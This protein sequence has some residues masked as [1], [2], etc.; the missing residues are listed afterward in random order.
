[1]SLKT[2]QKHDFWQIQTSKPHSNTPYTDLRVRLPF[3]L[4]YFLTSLYRL[5]REI[6]YFIFNCGCVKFAFSLTDEVEKK[7]KKSMFQNVEEFMFIVADV[8]TSLSIL[9]SIR[10]YIFFMQRDLKSLD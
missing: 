6:F 9:V 3:R 7:V 2:E 4:Y 1:L 5:A 10:Y 8:I